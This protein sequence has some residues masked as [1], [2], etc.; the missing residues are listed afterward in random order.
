MKK[1]DSVKRI[2]TL[3]VLLVV[4]LAGCSKTKEL[5]EPKG[6]TSGGGAKGKTAESNSDV[7][8]EVKD[9]AAELSTES[10]DEK[11]TQEE[12]VNNDITIVINLLNVTINDE[13]IYYS[14]ED[15]DEFN[16]KFENSIQEIKKDD[17]VVYL[18]DE[19]GDDKI[20]ENVRLL[21]SKIGITPIEI[22]D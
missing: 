8:T 20:A 10:V 3:L 9:N 15:L 14:H 12:I 1:I 5:G 2:F 19:T 18:K 7:K 11:I 6:L 21:L 16:V 22:K 13:K 4:L 17:T